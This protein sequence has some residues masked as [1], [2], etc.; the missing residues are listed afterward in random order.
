MSLEDLDNFVVDCN[1]KKEQIQFLQSL[2]PTANERITAKTQ[3]LLM[4]WHIF[5]DHTAYSQLELISRGDYD[6]IINQQLWLVQKLL[7]CLR[8]QIKFNIG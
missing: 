1:L 8:M 4:P 2:R 7:H 3:R 6:W 5:T